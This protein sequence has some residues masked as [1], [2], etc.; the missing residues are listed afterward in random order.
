[1]SVDVRD[2][3]RE[4]LP[5]LV[6][7]YQ[8]LS[9]DDPREDPEAIETYEAVLAAIDEHPAHHVLVAEEDGRLLGTATV[10][11]EP[12]LTYT[13]SPFALI[14]NVVVTEAARGRGVGAKIIER[15]VELAREAGCYKVTLTSNK[16]RKEA[17]RFYEGLGFTASHEG[18]LLRLP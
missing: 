14:E 1:V 11:I 3:Q 4:D 7:M 5:E 6:R 10:I 18:F 12:N 13:A 8:Q 17:H 15:C 16:R 9:L 2:A